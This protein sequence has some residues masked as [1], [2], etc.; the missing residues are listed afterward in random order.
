VTNAPEGIHQDG[1]DYIVSA[2]VIERRGVVGGE[3]IVLGPDKRTEYLRHTLQEGQGIFQADVG[4]P[5]W[6]WATPVRPA[7]P[8]SG[9]EAVR[10][11]LGYDV[12]QA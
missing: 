4:S 11:I 2:L 7:A 1:S 10:N 12:H 8:S 5:L 9:E 3:S 6:H